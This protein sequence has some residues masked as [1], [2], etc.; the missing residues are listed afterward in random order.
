MDMGRRWC[1]SV[2]V[3]SPTGRVSVTLMPFPFLF[4]FLFLFPSPMRSGCHQSPRSRS[5]SHCRS[6]PQCGPRS[7]YHSHPYPQS[8]PNSHTPDVGKVYEK[9]C[10]GV[11]KVYIDEDDRGREVSFVIGLIVMSILGISFGLHRPRKGRVAM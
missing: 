2:A 5:H 6:Y 9:C 8:I 3:S 11:G 1:D 7:R 4:L 10:F